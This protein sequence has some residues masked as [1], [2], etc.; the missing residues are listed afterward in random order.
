MISRADCLERDAA[1]SLGHLRRQFATDAIDAQQLIHL[2]GNS[3]GIPP[4]TVAERLQHV[5]HDEWASGLIR[6]WNTAGWIDLPGRV[7]DKIARL[8]A[9]RRAS[10][11]WPIR[12]PPISS[13]CSTRQWPWSVPMRR[14]GGGSYRSVAT[15]RPI[16]TSPTPVARAH[17]FELVLVDTGDVPSQL[18]ERLAILMLS[19]VNYRTGQLHRMGDVTRAAHDAGGLMVWDLAHSAG[20]MPIRLH[21]D[22]DATTPDFA[23]G[24]GYKYLNGGPGAPAFV[25]VNPQHTARMDREGWRQ[26]LSGWMGHAAPFDFR[27][28]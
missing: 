6:S 27:P 22:D 21:G 26:P 10:S 7:G 19:H 11:S 1:D 5:I 28:D 4:R 3:L 13:R 12:R 8:E 9:L 2:D 14:G 20:A 18:D 25:W 24:C 23:V 15:F 17:G 16:F